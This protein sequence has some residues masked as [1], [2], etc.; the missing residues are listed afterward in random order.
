MSLQRILYVASEIAPFLETSLV[1]NCVRKLPESMQHKQIDVR[2]IVPKFGIINDRLNRLHEVLRLSGSVVSINEVDYP[3]SVKV[4]TIPNTRL[5]VYF[6]DNTD[7][8]GG[9][10]SVF[11]DK[12]NVFFED[13]DL[14]MIFFCKGVIETLKKLE[15]EADIVHCHDWIT[16]LVPIF[17]KKLYQN[18]ALFTKA[19]LMV[20]VYNNTFSSH[21]PLLAQNLA[22]LGIVS[23][24]TT[25]LNNGNCRNI[26]QLAMH[27][28]DLVLK[29]ETLNAP[30]LID[31]LQTSASPIIE[32]DDHYTEN[33]FSAYNRL[34]SPIP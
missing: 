6:I 27:Y 11:S 12:Y 10:R 31:L 23:A 22:Q 14:R 16:S 33:Y 2:I 8:F 34:V 13:N 32:N 18:H 7:L 20:T 15:W 3:I 29:G 5:Q 25:L 24:D 4:G 17:W 28:A 30:E 9:R 26:I 21:F 1:A 19:K